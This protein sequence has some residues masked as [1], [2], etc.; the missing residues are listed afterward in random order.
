MEVTNLWD[1]LTEF[2]N[3]GIKTKSIQQQL[4]SWGDHTIQFIVKGGED[5]TLIIRKG[6]VALEKGKK[7]NPDLTFTALDGHLV[8]L[9][10]GQTD[11]TSLDIMGDIT[12]QGKP[13][14]RNRFIAILGLFV[15]AILGESDEFVNP[16]D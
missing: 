3:I 4:E 1:A 13:A 10:T 14:D 2:K 11:Y 6:K 9:L 15:D 12:F 16:E 8:N 5:C 7:E